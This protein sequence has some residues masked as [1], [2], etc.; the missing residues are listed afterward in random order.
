MSVNIDGSGSR[1]L[2]NLQRVFPHREEIIVTNA[3][4][5]RPGRSNSGTPPSHLTRRRSPLK[6]PEL[7]KRGYFSLDRELDNCYADVAP[8]IADAIKDR[9]TRPAKSMTENMGNSPGS[10]LDRFGKQGH[11]AK[12]YESKS[13]HYGFKEFWRDLF[14][15]KDN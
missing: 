5:H 2:H 8:L 15:A 12:I 6:R 4:T 11:T 7:A 13:P 14:S 9:A 3:T 1:L 10:I